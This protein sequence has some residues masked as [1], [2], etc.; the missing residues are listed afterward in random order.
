MCGGGVGMGFG[1]GEKELGSVAWCVGGF[2]SH[3]LGPGLGD[4]FRS[5]LVLMWVWSGQFCA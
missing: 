4:W 5:C 3:E 2:G 1:L